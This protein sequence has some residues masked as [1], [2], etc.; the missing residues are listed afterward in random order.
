MHFKASAAARAATA[1]VALTSIAYLP[2]AYGQ[3]ANF[4][5][6]PMR[7]VV[8]FTPGGASDVTARLI[9]E[10]M[11]NAF[12]QSVVVE[13]RP[14]AGGIVGTDV[15]AKA[16]PDGYTLGFVSISHAVKP[17]IYPKLPYDTMRDF[18]YLTMTADVG[19]VLVANNTLPVSSTADLIAL[20]KKDPGKISYASSG[21]GSSL[22][23]AMELLISKTGMKLIHVPYKGS[24]Q[25]HPDVLS[26]QVP[27]MIDTILAISPHIKSGRVK[28]LGVTAKKRSQLLPDVPPIADTVPG[29]E[30]G[31]WGGM[32]APARL[33]AD[34]K[35]KIHGEIVRA[36]KASDV[37]DKLAALGA[38]VVANSPEEFARFIQAEITKWAVVTKAAGIK[39]E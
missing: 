18:T 25:A 7:I 23:L 6:R 17:G 32:I 15:V 27:V 30:A 14:S 26:G 4:P 24:T 29:Y 1:V 5:T 37:R 31:S 36:L 35:Q 33:P 38:D 34:L 13:N 3:P 22:H 8:P 20:A 16:S 10:K 28:A 11:T 9:A 12:K 21:A 2:G 39:A 19:L